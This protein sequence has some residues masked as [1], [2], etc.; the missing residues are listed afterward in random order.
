MRI[1]GFVVNTGCQIIVLDRN[2]D[3]EKNRTEVSEIS[4]VNLRAGWKELTKPINRYSSSLVQEVAG[5]EVSHLCG[6]QKG[7][8]LGPSN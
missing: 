2:V 6:G 4:L 5:P 3:I 7:S 8:G 1:C